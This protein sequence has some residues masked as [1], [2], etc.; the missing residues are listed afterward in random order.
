MLPY[1]LLV[2]VLV[3]MGVLGYREFH[4]RSRRPGIRLKVDTFD[5]HSDDIKTAVTV[6]NTGN[7]TETQV[8]V[9]I[10]VKAP[11]SST[12]SCQY[13]K[14][15]AHRIPRV[16]AAE[17]PENDE[18]I[19]GNTCIFIADQIAPEDELFFVVESSE[20]LNKIH[21][22]ATAA[23]VSEAYVFPQEEGPYAGVTGF[24]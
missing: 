1:L 12:L 19:R 17:R 18:L 3:L 16:F 21:V 6:S 13:M 20:P 14:A 15:K 10:A 22:V 4:A 2:V 9:L 7:R 5:F 11:A 8:Q 24:G 23:T